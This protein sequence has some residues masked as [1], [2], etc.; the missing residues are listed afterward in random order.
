MGRS[1]RCWKRQNSTRDEMNPRDA[2]SL[3]IST[4][5]NL[6]PL[7]R[8][9]GTVVLRREVIQALIDLKLDPVPL[10]K[11]KLI[12]AGEV[13]SILAKA[14]VSTTLIRRA[15][16]SS[17]WAV[18]RASGKIHKEKP[19]VQ[20]FIAEAYLAEMQM[21]INRMSL[22]FF[23]LTQMDPKVARAALKCFGKHELAAIWLTTPLKQ[24]WNKTPRE[25]RTEDV[26]QV[27][28]RMENGVFG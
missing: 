22:D 27:L 3:P 4:A 17:P 16:S 24:L 8:R 7:H 23:Y 13:E 9:Q 2:P 20:E 10:P 28:E 18:R 14:G 25:C 21:R 5:L 11:G 15:V 6:H 19:S 1:R 26:L 12:D